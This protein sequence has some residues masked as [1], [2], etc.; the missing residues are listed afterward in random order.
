MEPFVDKLLSQASI[1]EFVLLYSALV[2]IKDR[3]GRFSISAHN[4]GCVIV[5]TP[6]DQDIFFLPINFPEYED[7]QDT[8]ALL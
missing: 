2:R 3:I 8:S 1:D 7:D 6:Y 5:K 4:H